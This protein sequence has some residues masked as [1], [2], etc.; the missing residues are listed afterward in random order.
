MGYHVTYRWGE[1]EEG[2][3]EWST[4]HWTTLAW[5][6]ED[7]KNDPDVKAGKF[8]DIVIHNKEM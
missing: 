8:L 1:N 5:V 4:R 6:L 2:Q 3:H 7:I